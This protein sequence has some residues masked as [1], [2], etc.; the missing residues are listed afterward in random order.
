M[1]AA[2]AVCVV[3]ICLGV[4]AP[5]HSQGTGAQRFDF[6]CKAT[7]MLRGVP[8]EFTTVLHVDLA[9]RE[10][11]IDSCQGGPQPI[12]KVEAN[13]IT[14]ADS[15]DATGSSHIWVDRPSGAYVHRQK[16]VGF[17]DFADTG[18]CA[19]GPFSGFPPRP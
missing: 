6:V 13:R 16:I 2:R 5:G 8:R 1:S 15:D 19:P 12:A 7:Q 9:S 10:W 11:C 4:A 14:F 17:F 18:D 3:A